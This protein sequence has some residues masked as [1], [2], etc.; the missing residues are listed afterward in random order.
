MLRRCG[1][2]AD[3]P[4]MGPAAG[5][6]CCCAATQR[7]HRDEDAGGG[8]EHVSTGSHIRNT[9]ADRVGRCKPPRIRRA[10]R[11]EKVSCRADGGVAGTRVA[12]VTR[13]VRGHRRRRRPGARA[14]RAARVDAA[15]A[16]ARSAR[17]GRRSHPCGRR[18]RHAVVR[19]RH[20][21]RRRARGHSTRPSPPSARLDIVVANA[22]AGFHGSLLDTSPDAMARLIDVNSWARSC[23]PGRAPPPASR[24]RAPAD[25]RV[26]H[27]GPARPGLGQRLRRDQVRPGRPRRSLRA[28]LA[29]TSVRVSVVFP[30]STET[31]FRDAMAR[32]QGFAIQGHGPRQSA[33]HVAARIVRGIE[34]GAARDLPARAVEAA[35]DR[36]APR[37]PAPGRPHCPALRPQARCQ[38]RRA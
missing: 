1:S 33:E 3:G 20:R 17:R 11:S 4:A 21:G 27:R 6:G 15:G 32:E 5:A 37:W 14:R 18:A 9:L 23:G 35:V 30:V 26:V 13:R 38:R 29:G 28:E 2:G 16:P 34:S 10:R 7:Q 25:H 12:L 8:E 19:R 36:R 22:G 24:R 31:E